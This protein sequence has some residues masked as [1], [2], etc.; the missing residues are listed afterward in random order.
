MGKAR[1]LERKDDW[2]EYTQGFGA[3]RL[4]CCEDL[5]VKLCH[6]TLGQRHETCNT[7]SELVIKELG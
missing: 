2:A 1:V 4:F 5:M 7:K 3:A 6:N